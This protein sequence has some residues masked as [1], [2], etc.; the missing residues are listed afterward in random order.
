[1]TWG[2][3]RDKIILWGGVILSAF[4]IG[5]ATGCKR[6]SKM[7]TETQR[8]TVMVTV[9]DTMPV[10]VRRVTTKYVPLP[11]D[12]VRIH[13]TI[14]IPVKQTVYAGAD[15]RAWV[16]GIQASLDSIHIEQRTVT[17]TEYKKE[18]RKRWGIGPGVGYGVNGP[19]I[20]LGITYHI[21]QW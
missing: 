2:K 14:Y 9:R 21:I 1:M 16:S 7:A 17:L 20:G 11:A 19:Y 10:A 13:D 18:K 12:T 6:Q 4:I 15:Y 5:Y 3:L 8:D